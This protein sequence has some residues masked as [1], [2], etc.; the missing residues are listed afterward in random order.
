MPNNYSKM[1]RDGPIHT[2]DVLLG[3][4]H[5]KD[6]YSIICQTC[7]RHRGDHYSNNS[8]SPVIFCDYKDLK[9]YLATGIVEGPRFVPTDGRKMIYKWKS[10]IVENAKVVMATSDGLAKKGQVGIVINRDED[11]ARVAWN[12]GLSY[13]HHINNLSL[14]SDST[15]P[16]LL[17]LVRKSI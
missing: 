12:N 16:N 13:R 2:A 7:G 17:F 15:D 14:L 3:G 8:N 9:H 5:I 11:T 1:D 6:D 10:K 4:P